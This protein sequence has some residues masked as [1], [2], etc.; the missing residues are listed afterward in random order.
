MPITVNTSQ[1]RP[2]K[3]DPVLHA[4]NKWLTWLIEAAIIA[5]AVLVVIIVRVKIYNVSIVISRSMEPTLH[6]G[7][8]L[9]FDHRSSIQGQWKRGDIVFFEPPPT[10]Q[11]AEGD[12]LVKRLIALPNE[13]IFIRAGHVYVDNQEITEGMV[14]DGNDNLGPR[15]LGPDEYFVLGDNR[16]NSDDSRNQGPIRKQDIRGRAVY[17]LWP[18]PGA[19]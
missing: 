1:P 8:R 4:N 19:L 16:G 14:E 17:R 5:L 9:V 15:K 10:W 11:D 3:K 2:P 7:D 12:L 18:S 13:T 6:I